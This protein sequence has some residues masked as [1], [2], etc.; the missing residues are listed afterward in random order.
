MN[1]MKNGRVFAKKC[2]VR[3][4]SANHLTIEACTWARQSN[5]QQKQHG[6]KKKKRG[7]EKER[8]RGR[9]RKP[10]DVSINQKAQASSTKNSSKG[11]PSGEREHKKS[12]LIPKVSSVSAS[13][14]VAISRRC[15]LVTKSKREPGQYHWQGTRGCSFWSA[16]SLSGLY[17]GVRINWTTN[18]RPKNHFCVYI[19]ALNFLPGH[20]PM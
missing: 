19:H 13:S 5:K 7:R 20:R 9:R 2:L 3:F 4:L 14:M 11:E 6:P 15:L 10:Q 17:P 12:F 16:S 1:P 18:L 8:K